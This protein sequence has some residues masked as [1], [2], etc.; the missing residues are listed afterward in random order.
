MSTNELTAAFSALNIGDK[1][2]VTFD[3]G[4]R[5][6]TIVGVNGAYVSTSAGTQVGRAKGGAIVNRD[7]GI[8][9]QATWSQPMRAVL[10]IAAV[11]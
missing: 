8:V 1:V 10:S 6:V 7:D 9:F 2:L 4:S 3:G 11:N 5:K